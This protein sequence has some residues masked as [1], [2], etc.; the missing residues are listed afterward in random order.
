MSSSLCA[1]RR[2][3][4]LV[5]AVFALAA[6]CVAPNQ[7]VE[8]ASTTTVVAEQS[9]D[10]RVPSAD[11]PLRVVFAGDSV[12]AGLVPPLEAAFAETSAAEGRFVLTPSI[13]RDPAVFFTWERHLEEFDPEVVIVLMGTWEAMII[14]GEAGIEDLDTTEP[15]WGDVYRVEVLAPWVE[16]LAEGGAHVIWVGMPAVNPG[17]PAVRILQ[18]NLAVADLARQ[19]E[20]L[21]YVDPAPLAGEVA[22]GTVHETMIIDGR[23]VRVRQVDGLH[24]C[25]AGAALLAEP[26]LAELAK[27]VGL[28]AATH[29]RTGSWDQHEMSPGAPTYPEH[30][31][32]PVDAP[33]T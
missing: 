31:C 1:L 10:D 12:M 8:D 23:E 25:P 5:A 26:V 9:I 21:T 29:W 2:S 3:R 30:A 4:I 33:P 16:L 24:L 11:D 19:R 32:P 14:E 15:S 28:P 7:L 6:A 27:L 22:T 13:V 18:L 17:A 20:Y